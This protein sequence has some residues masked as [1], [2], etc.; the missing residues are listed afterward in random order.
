VSVVAIATTATPAD[1]DVETVP[2]HG[3]QFRASLIGVA[4]GAVP[5]LAT[6]W[7]YGLDP[8]RTAVPSRLFSQFFDEQARA[9]L[10]GELSVPLGTLGIEGFRHDGHEYM[11][12]GPLPAL[13]RLPFVALT[14]GLDGRLTAV[15]MLLAWIVAASFVALTV[16]RVRS[17]VTPER[18]LHRRDLVAASGFIA[19]V[20]GGSPLLLLAATPW[21]Y[22]EAL[23]WAFAM[24]AGSL[25]ALLGVLQ[26]PSRARIAATA[27]LTL[28]AVLSRVT[29]GWGCA[30]AVVGVGVLFAVAPCRRQ[31]RRVAGWVIAAGLVPLG[32]GIAIN[33]AKFG[34]P[35][36]IPFESQVWTAH[37]AARRAA[38]AEGGVVGTRFLPSTLVNYLRPDGFRL[39]GVFPFL[40][41]P[42]APAVEV[43]RVN[44]EM[45][46]RTPSA[47]A[48]MPLLFVLGVVG[49]WVI[50][51]PAASLGRASLRI[52]LLGAISITGGML[53]V[54]YIAP[55][56]LVEFLPALVIAGSA[57]LAVVL[58]R[59]GS[60]SSRRRLLATLA[61]A[62]LALFG[63]AANAATALSSAR[64]TAG[65]SALGELVEAQKWVSDRTGR[66]LDGLVTVGER[67]PARSQPDQLFV[68]GGCEGLLVG[69]GELY[70]PWVP[71]EL[72]PVRLS[73]R[74]TG[75]I[76]PGQFDVVRFDGS[77]GVA[78]RF[79]FD[80]AGGYRVVTTGTGGGPYTKSAW[81]PVV[82]DAVVEI[83]VR[84]NLVREGYLIDAPGYVYTS[85][86]L[87]RHLQDPRSQI[88]L[89]RPV[90]SG[91]EAVGNVD[92]TR[93]RPAASSLCTS[94][95][96][97][98]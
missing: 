39:S 35:V 80:G 48:F 47:T 49:T 81:Q 90:T 96:G 24:A 38:L 54:D 91:G 2:D 95:L 46:Y 89:A 19:V 11:Y 12:F 61:G 20:L 78:L 41:P 51:R 44:V 67:L 1:L 22:S 79:E 83:E 92:V 33:L 71:V 65:G 77:D 58:S 37:S 94:L 21:V 60:W 40:A 30:L 52:P 62:I 70:Q 7:D 18:E 98:D 4:V 75:A 56:Y 69:T 43:G 29:A 68:V 42:A 26:A 23:L 6:L 15:S 86:P 73:A 50:A 27:V 32:V 8:L 72:A 74:L 16:W 64:W 17:M 66:P 28:G 85:T 82:R 36:M 25:Y 14:D 3:R 97:S 84:P 34:H 5:F 76:R 9:F 55:R 13:V 63:L 87:V 53:L 88:V 45:R 59:W 10:R 57:G 31:H 93:H